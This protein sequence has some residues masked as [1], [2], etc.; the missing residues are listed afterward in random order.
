ML[1]KIS[2]DYTPVK[3]RLHTRYAPVRRSSADCK[4]SLL[5]LDLHVLGL[6]L[7]FIL[8]Q[9]QTLRCNYSYLFLKN[10]YALILLKDIYLF[11]STSISSKNSLF[12]PLLSPYSPSF[13]LKRAAKVQLFSF[14]QNFF[15]LFFTFYPHSPLIT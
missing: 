5:P 11:F 9:D 3:G 7:A 12:L 10:Y 15:L 1:F 4:Q 13:R 8:S 14:S 2:L 6:P